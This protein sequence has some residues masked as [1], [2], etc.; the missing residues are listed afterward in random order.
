[1][2]PPVL[3]HKDVEEA[4]GFQLGDVP[5]FSYGEKHTVRKTPAA[6]PGGLVPERQVPTCSTACDRHKAS[7]SPHTTVITCTCECVMF[8]AHVNRRS[9]KREQFVH[10]SSRFLSIIRACGARPEGSHLQRP[11]QAPHSNL[12]SFPTCIFAEKNFKIHTI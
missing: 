11:L 3:F 5:Q 1:M 10:I 6:R 9:F 8:L 4:P 12:A 7:F 2:G